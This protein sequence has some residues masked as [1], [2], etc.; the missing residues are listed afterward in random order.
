MIRW[1]K[2]QIQFINTFFFL[3]EMFPEFLLE[4]WTKH[5]QNTAFQD[6]ES[7]SFL[8]DFTNKILFSVTICTDLSVAQRVVSKAVDFVRHLSAK[9][10]T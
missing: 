5:R 1:G 4:D 8:N 6:A 7:N 9:I 2:P 3:N 10:L